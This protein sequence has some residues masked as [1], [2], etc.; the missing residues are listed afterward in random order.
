MCKY[1]LVFCLTINI[2]F[3]ADVKLGDY[4]MTGSGVIEVLAKYGIKGSDARQV[5]GHVSSSLT[6]LGDKASG[7]LKEDLM[8]ILAKL[9]VT[10]S[11]VSI[12]KGLQTLLNIPS[13]KIT[14]PELVEAINSIIYLANRHGK[15]VLITC[16][17]C[18]NENLA[19][20]GFKFTVETIKDSQS[21]KLLNDVI[22]KNPAQLHTFISRR[23]KKFGMG[24]YS[25]VTLSAV[26]P[27]DEKSLALFLGLAETGSVEQK[28]LIESI[29]KVS[30]IKGKMPNI[31]DPKNP[32]KFWKILADD[33]SSQDMSG[34]I[35]TL[36]VVAARIQKEG[37]TAEEAFYH[38]LKNKAQGNEYLTKQY[39][40]LKAK[41]CFFK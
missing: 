17:E 25:K 31:I 1:L 22:P 39:E 30:T 23:M 7:L 6:S 13:E 10:G 3:A 9:P 16:A 4:L 24:D 37:V 32:H 33:M 36:D 41:R 40:A 12:R 27:E 19:K 38:T 28:K 20:D 11:D 26:L 29:V 18:V 34:W 15:S 14:K 35:K 5:Q 2:L 21:I 8:G